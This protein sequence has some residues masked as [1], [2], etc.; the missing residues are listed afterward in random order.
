MDTQPQTADRDDGIDTEWVARTNNHGS[1]TRL[2]R[3]HP[4]EDVTDVD[5]GQAVTVA[6]VEQTPVNRVYR[7]KPAAAIPDGYYATC[8]R[9]ECFGSDSE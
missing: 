5:N 4:D 1:K 9:P 8:D 6:C 7:A 3:L 2:H